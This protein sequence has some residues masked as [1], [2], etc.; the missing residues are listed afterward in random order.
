MVKLE[1]L[2]RRCQQGELAAFSKLFQGYQARVYRLAV[3]ILRDEQDAED[4]VQDVFVRVFERIRDYRGDSAFTTWLTAIVVNCCCDKLRR[5]KVRRALA[6]D[7]LRGRASDQ[8]LNEVVTRRQ[9][10]QTL[11]A[12]VDRLDEKHR[13]PVILHYHEGLSCD[14]VARALNLRTSTVYSR[15]NTARVR[16]RAMLREQSKSERLEFRTQAEH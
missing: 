2:V 8:D 7:R 15:L 11:W 4:A 16:L 1:E 3:A 13:L 10:R 9:Q 14:E 5:R 12:L 6:L